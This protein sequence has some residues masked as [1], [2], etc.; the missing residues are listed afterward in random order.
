M[1]IDLAYSKKAQKMQ[2]QN[3]KYLHNHLLDALTNSIQ[4]ETRCNREGWMQNNAGAWLI[5]KA[6]L[7]KLRDR[8]WRIA[9]RSVI[10]ISVENLPFDEL[11]HMLGRV[12]AQSQHQNA[13]TSSCLCKGL[14]DNQDPEIAHLEF[15]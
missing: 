2:V 10:S 15:L 5:L 13:C 14:M 7:E 6:I 11:L 4:L 3:S 9:K 1:E 8:I 12:L